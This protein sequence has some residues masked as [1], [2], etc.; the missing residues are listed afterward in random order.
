MESVSVRD[1]RNH[2]GDVI[3]RVLGGQTLEV[4]RDGAPV[5]ALTPLP[6]RPLSRAELLRRFRDAP[7]VDPARLRADVDAVIDQSL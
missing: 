4:T 3:E 1:L 6:R 2:G 5:A 7:P